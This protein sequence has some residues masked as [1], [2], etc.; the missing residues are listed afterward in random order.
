MCFVTKAMPIN[1]ID[2]KHHIMK[3]KSCVTCLTGFQNHVSNNLCPQ[4]E[5]GHRDKDIR[6]TLAFIA[7][8]CLHGLKI[9]PPLKN[10]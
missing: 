10:F 9:W 2:S 8:M 6:Y 1:N 7:S 3:V 5:D 4:G